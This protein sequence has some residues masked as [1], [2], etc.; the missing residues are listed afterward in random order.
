MLYD[1]VGPRS[2]LAR[3]FPPLPPA[4]GPPHLVISPLMRPR[5]LLN[6][7][8]LAPAS[9]SARGVVA[10]PADPPVP[11]P[12]PVTMTPP[13]TERTMPVPLANAGDAGGSSLAARRCCAARSSPAPPAAPG[14]ADADDAADAEPRRSASA[15][16]ASSSHSE[17]ARV[18]RVS[19]P[20][21]LSRPPT[22]APAELASDAPRRCV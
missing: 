1:N 11:P 21:R 15:A 2:R 13:L 4:L 14:A 9:S 18:A 6:G 8:A 7:F 19:P 20:S 17:S 22:P 3:P 10:T 5:I 16:S 12:P